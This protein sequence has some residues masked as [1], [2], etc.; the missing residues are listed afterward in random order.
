MTILAFCILL[1]VLPYQTVLRYMEK[2]VSQQTNSLTEWTKRHDAAEAKA[3]TPPATT[4]AAPTPPATVVPK[5]D[6][7]SLKTSGPND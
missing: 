4:P 6:H 1:G 7:L 2:T 5:N 3:N